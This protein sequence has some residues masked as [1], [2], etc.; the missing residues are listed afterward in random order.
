MPKKS[1][2]NKQRTKQTK[3][4][5]LKQTALTYLWK[6]NK[7]LQTNSR[8]HQ[9]TSNNNN[10]KQYQSP[11]QEQSNKPQASPTNTTTAKKNQSEAPK[12][13]QTTI[14]DLDTLNLPFGDNILDEK[15]DNI[16]LFHNINGM[17]EEKN[18]YQILATMRDLNVDI[19]G[20]AEVNRS[21]NRGYSNKWTAMIKNVFYYSRHINSESSIQLETPY[22]PGGTITTI[23]GKWQ[24][25]VTE[26]GQDR[27]GL[28]RWSYI[29]ITSKKVSLI[30]M[31]AYRPVAS[32]GPSTV[33]MQHWVMLREK[34][35]RNPDPIKTFYEDLEEQLLEWKSNNKEIIVMI[36][37]NEQIGE[38][39]SRLQD[40][41]RKMEMTELIRYKHPE[42]DEPNTHIRGTKRIDYIFGTNRVT[43][44][45]NRA[46]ILPFGT[47]Y[48]SDHRALFID[49]AIENIL[50]TNVSAIDS[51]TARKLIQA[52]PKE[53]HFFIQSVNEYLENQNV[54]E[55]LRLLHDKTSTW[56]SSD[57]NEYE[58]CDETLIQGMLWAESKTRRIRTTAWSPKFGAAVAKKSFWKIA[59]SLKSNCRRPNEDFIRWAESLGIPDF[60]SLSIQ[61]VKKELKIAQ[62]ELREIEQKA[63]ELRIE[64][65]KE[66]LTEAELNGGDQKVQRCIKIILRA[67][68]QKQ[69]FQRLKRIFK[70][71]TSGGLSYILVPKDFSAN[72]Y[73][74]DPKEVKKWETIHDPAE[75]ETFIQKRNIQHFG[76][77]Q[78]SPFTIP[79]LNKLKWQANSIEAK[80]II[81][82]SIPTSFLTENPY[83]NKV[84]RYIAQREKL[85]EID[86]YILPEQVSK[87]F[88][89][90]RET[91]ST[92]PSGCH[93]GLRRIAT[94][95]SED[96]E[97]EESRKKVL[98][99]QT[100]IIN[101]PIQRGFS[102]TRWRKVVNAMLEKIPGKPYLHKLRVI[103]IL[104]A[105]YNLALKEIFGRR[106]MWN[107]EQLNKLGDIQDGFRKGRS[108]I[109]TL[110]HAE[111]VNDYNK[112][113]RINNFV[114]MTDISGCFDRIVTPII[115]L[116]NRKNGCPK[117]AVEMH[118]TNLERAQYYLKTR[119]GTSTSF[120]SNTEANPIHGNGQ[121]AGD[122][123]SQWCQQSTLLFDLYD[124]ENEGAILT[125]PTVQTEV[126]IPLT[127]FADD[128][129]LIGN[130]N[131]RVLDISGLVTKA[132]T[133]F[134]SWNQLLHAT[135]HFMEL[136]KCACYLSIWDFQHDGYAFTLDPDELGH[137]VVV[138]DLHGNTIEIP[139][140]P[141]TT[142]QKMLGVMR[143]PI[144][145]Q[146][147]EVK[148]LK[149]K[150]DRMASNLNAN[151]LSRIEAKLAYEC[152]YI[153]AMRYSLAITSINQ[154]DLENVQQ[155]TV[156]SL[157]SA[158]GYNR[159][160]PREVIF[161]SQRYQGIGLKHLYDLQGTDGVRLLIQE[162]NHKGST[163][164]R[165]LRIILETIQ[166]EAGIQQPILEENR[167]LQYIEWGWIPSIRDF[168]HHINAKIRNATKGLD[169]YRENDVLIMDY[170]SQITASYKDQML[171]NRCR[172]R[173]Q[174][175]C[176]SDITNSAG[177]HVDKAWYDDN[178]VKPSYSTKRWP[179][180][181]DPG[182][183]AWTIW[184]SFIQR[185]F[186]KTNGELRKPLGKWTRSNS[187]RMHNGYVS[188]DFRKLYARNGTEKWIIHKMTASTRRRL[189]YEPQGT[190]ADVLPE[191]IIP[192]DII[193]QDKDGVTTAV[194]AGR[195]NQQKKKNSVSLSE[196][197][198]EMQR[199]KRLHDVNVM[200]EEEELSK[201]LSNR[202]LADVATDGS[203]D[204]ETGKMA[205]GW[206]IAINEKIIA[207]GKGPAEASTHLAESF[208]AEAYGLRA[209]T[210][211]IQ[212][213]LRCKQGPGPQRW[214]FHIDNRTLIT[215]MER[216]ST[217][218]AM[219]KWVHDPDID[220]TNMVQENLRGIEAQFLHVKSH[221]DRQHNQ[222]KL[223]FPAQLN[224]RADQLATGQQE[225]MKYPETIITTDFCHLTIG[226]HYITRDS[227]R[228]L[229]D[230][231]SM[232]PIRQYYSD[233][234]GWSEQ[235]FQSIDWDLQHKVLQRYG[236]NDQRRILKFVHGWLPT[237]N[238]LFREKR[239]NTTR[240][241]LCFY[242][243]EDAVHLFSCIQTKQATTKE[244]L[245]NK[246]ATELKIREPIK[247]VVQKAI[248]MTPHNPQW[249]PDNTGSR[250]LSAQTRIGWQQL[251]FGRL[252]KEL[253]HEF[254]CE[255]DTSKN[256]QANKIGMGQKLIRLIWD[257]FLELWQQR[258]DL[259]FGETSRST[260]DAQRRT[261]IA[262]VEQCYELE[263]TLDWEDRTKIFQHSKEEVLA[264]EPRKIAAW[265][266][267]A[268]QMIRINKVEKR[269]Q[270]GQKNLMEQY[271]KWHPPDSH[272]G[273][274]GK[275]RDQHHKQNLKPD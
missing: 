190:A 235:T 4:E 9:K 76:Q 154:L 226:K 159:H 222:T 169:T 208:R 145:N 94:Y 275:E 242:V 156:M 248:E 133:A 102:P 15:Q 48:H 64:H 238:R 165:L 22:K 261:W 17:K 203:Y 217:S 18:W 82:G 158:L 267:L 37:A 74:Y 67:Q 266:K 201:V 16:I 194:P 207:E 84:L 10:D 232:I 214:F 79:P 164:N 91:T 263:T 144:G 104:E 264:Q 49:I 53:R 28:G 168:L 231:A 137:K 35:Q 129:N 204:P 234:Y 170:V 80:E 268:E 21:L 205:Y 5:R 233:K 13:I 42:R 126:R 51:I 60:K 199:T 157:T 83:T 229:L 77:A 179:R 272:T 88:R 216:Y 24:S 121:G 127:A 274:Y 47:G 31:T 255:Q 152:F 100:D 118:A 106:L 55:R 140:L 29:Q 1:N 195:I 239:Q 249:Q 187:T 213:L 43:K 99:A 45:C 237:N 19:F 41:F 174:V 70:P 33:W 173:L 6:E 123:P 97:T 125:D 166:L 265:V 32:Q 26:M 139:L 151:A 87:G 96:T 50:S 243:V 143:N 153:P 114:G 206:I 39:V 20:F 107:C 3:Y 189:Q 257:A 228:W 136:E 57:S 101:I 81:E 110:L 150:S 73:P 130:D 209:A 241:P 227:Q 149:E 191:G 141:A 119:H 163:T 138:R 262:K 25:R 218:Q 124:A 46:G 225:S 148:R 250:G 192:V 59:L 34:G 112:R 271:F 210:T 223:S 252:A 185:A 177:T 200:I 63:E 56:T 11:S 171:I 146:Q 247:S 155:N 147:D 270:T 142:S 172:I 211:F 244:R 66:R 115:S 253:V 258:N 254:E 78:G 89:K 65:L 120:Y 246:I 58:A 240:C 71:T 178:S 75:L 245:I 269:K 188:Q 128:T 36:D 196:T 7:Q 224:G 259:V 160:M 180:Q 220:V 27:K 95:S 184:K 92:S 111:L 197:L 2:H 134:T 117:E 131:E 72:E 14:S 221:Q 30:I 93:L 219:A 85:P 40:I 8:T 132:Q 90:W 113:L 273:E 23:T 183:E 176:L 202:S 175:E 122:S 62:R 61:T 68:R 52:T 86:T 108:T 182:K 116:I 103:H 135:G 181:S 198:Q 167:P 161:C 186:L 162:L 44:N 12:Y 212:A 260:K 69:Y 109:K 193:G 215:R 256:R 251:L 38:K 236:V 230:S 105:D 54:Y 98:K